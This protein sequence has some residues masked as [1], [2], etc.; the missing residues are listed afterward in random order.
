MLTPSIRCDSCST[1]ALDTAF[2]NRNIFGVLTK[3]S[4]TVSSQNWRTSKQNTLVFLNFSHMNRIETRIERK[5]YTFLNFL[6]YIL[7]VVK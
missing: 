2:K 4:M 5:M 1:H 3:F 6:V 7:S